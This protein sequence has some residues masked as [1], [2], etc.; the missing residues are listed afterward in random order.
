MY[1]VA[2]LVSNKKSLKLEEKV[3]NCEQLAPARPPPLLVEGDIDPNTLL[4]TEM[5]DLFG[6]IIDDHSLKDYASKAGCC[7][8]SRVTYTTKLGTALIQYKG[9]P[10]GYLILLCF[11]H[12]IYSKIIITGV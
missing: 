6:G 9:Q 11:T 1:T 2:S 4:F 5:I 12:E 7:T 8:V 10:G 3:L